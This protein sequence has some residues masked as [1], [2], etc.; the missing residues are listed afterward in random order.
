MAFKVQTLAKPSIPEDTSDEPIDR[1]AQAT[2][3]IEI[4]EEEP[5]V[6]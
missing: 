2:D 6:P 1:A 4:E 5:G 3:T